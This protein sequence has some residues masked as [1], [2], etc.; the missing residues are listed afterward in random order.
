[1]GKKSKNPEQVRDLSKVE[2]AAKKLVKQSASLQADAEFDPR[3]REVI[4]AVRKAANL[5]YSILGTDLV[6]MRSAEFTR[7]CFDAILIGDYF[8]GTAGPL[9]AVW[10]KTGKRSA[11]P[12]QAF[13]P[14]F[15]PLGKDRFKSEALVLPMERLTIRKPG[16]HMHKFQ[17]DCCLVPNAKLIL[18]SNQ[19]AENLAQ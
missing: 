17:V 7:V 13:S 18:L 14:T 8:F 2:K 12:M 4:K 15:G 9:E 6:A 1:M 5:P 10:L 16:G 3:K 19:N 11:F